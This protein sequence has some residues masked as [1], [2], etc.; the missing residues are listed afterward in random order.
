MFFHRNCAK[1][2][3]LIITLLLTTCT[4][5][6]KQPL[7]QNQHYLTWQQRLHQLSRIRSW[8]IYGALGIK[9]DNKDSM[10]HFSWRQVTDN[11]AINIYTPINLGGVKITGSKKQVILWRSSS[12]KIVAE[13]PEQLMHKELGWSLPLFDLRYWV[14]G[15]PAPHV[16][17]SAKFDSY[18]HLS[19]LQQQGWQI[20]YSD[21][22]SIGNIDL[23][24]KISLNIPQ[25][26]VKLVVKKW[27]IFR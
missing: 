12:E 27:R 20:N 15:L 6:H 2:S 18:N 21:F 25:L 23:P 19:F 1:V 7:K 22:Q 10:A 13:T 5:L 9:Y 8:N 11:F 24:T 16:P 4:T 17:F 3:L 26:Q 14:L